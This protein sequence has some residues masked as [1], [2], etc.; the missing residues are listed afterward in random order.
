MSGWG[1]PKSAAGDV[2]GR[3]PR[4]VDGREQDRASRRLGLTH[5]LT[6]PRAPEPAKP[7]LPARPN[8]DDLPRPRSLSPPRR[9]LA[10]PSVTGSALS[11]RLERASFVRT[12]S[13]SS[14][15]PPVP[16]PPKTRARFSAKRGELDDVAADGSAFAADGD[17][18]ADAAPSP[19]PSRGAEAPLAPPTP[20][21]AGSS[22]SSGG[23][24]RVAAL[25]KALES[26]RKAEQAQR[27]P[28]DGDETPVM[29]LPDVITEGQAAGERRM[30]DSRSPL[31]HTVGE[32]EQ[33]PVAV[34][35]GA[36]RVG[37]VRGRGG[38]AAASQ[39]G[40]PRSPAGGIGASSPVYG[41]GNSQIQ[42]SPQ[43]WPTE[44]PQARGGGESDTTPTFSSSNATNRP[45]FFNAYNAKQE[46]DDDDEDS[47]GPGFLRGPT[48]Y[49]SP[50]TPLSSRSA[51]P[52]PS[53]PRSLTPS[54]PAGPPPASPC[55]APAGF[56]ADGILRRSARDNS[57]STTVRLGGEGDDAAAVRVGEVPPSP[58]GTTD[59]VEWPGVK[60]VAQSAATSPNGGGGGI[61]ACSSPAPVKPPPLPPHHSKLPSSLPIPPPE[62]PRA[63]EDGG[64]DPTTTTATASA[65][66]FSHEATSTSTAGVSSS[67][68]PPPPPTPPRGFRP[69]EAASSSQR[70]VS[71]P[72]SSPPAAAASSPASPPRVMSSPP[73]SSSLA[74]SPATTTATT[75]PAARATAAAAAASPTKGKGAGGVA[76]SL[77]ADD[78]PTPPPKMYSSRQL[79]QQQQQ[80]QQQ[81]RFSTQRGSSFKVKSGGGGS[82]VVGGGGNEDAMESD[83]DFIRELTHYRSGA[84][85]AARNDEY[86]FALVLNPNDEYRDAVEV[87][88]LALDL[89]DGGGG[90]TTSPQKLDKAKRVRDSLGG[91]QEQQQQ[92]QQQQQRSSPD[93]S[94]ASD[95]PAGLSTSQSGPGSGRKGGGGPP[96][97]RPG[98]SEGL[99]GV[100]GGRRTR[101]SLLD[102]LQEEEGRLTSRRKKELER[103]KK[104]RL[105]HFVQKMK[106]GVI[107]RRH[108]AHRTCDQIVLQSTDDCRTISWKPLLAADGGASGGGGGAISGL[109]QSL[110]RGAAGSRLSKKN[111][112]ECVKTAHI[113]VVLPATDPDPSQPG[114]FGTRALRLSEDI[115]NPSRTFSL[116][117]GD[118]GRGHCGMDDQV[119]GTLDLECPDDGMYAM[120]FQ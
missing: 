26:Q 89:G 82:P 114:F 3:S 62:T 73:S 58:A 16:P 32:E 81:Q 63:V 100:G 109:F 4:A 112:A 59:G 27:P 80:Q 60:H 67:S 43:Y 44:S 17:D 50:T 92:Q 53:P 96:V 70:A 87:L 102:D 115:P 2:G 6:S 105:F 95:S 117:Y 29:T 113:A 18:V 31:P 99:E 13:S 42:A 48:S 98:L 1:T 108:L 36:K 76:S 15:G 61:S 84:E 85:R 34:G 21:T 14:N 5:S 69:G 116:L 64:V 52:P 11:A 107:I 77:G 56:R 12:A 118:W 20:A 74:L 7:E 91:L 46:D 54:Q 104:H 90:V 72:T 68:S 93:R 22:S 35:M 25:A 88:E 119:Q 39:R 38:A 49:N 9:N 83:L 78:L 45:S 65:F 55:G 33:S 51:S 75:S 79:Q 47:M 110:R 71:S 106:E 41:T 97:V 30:M 24:G 23:G 37:R 66:S 86:E 40:G 10:P 28:E 19:T 101:L 120:L 94:G 57:S 103:K 111:R 8:S